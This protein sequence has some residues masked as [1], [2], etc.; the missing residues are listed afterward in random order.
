MVI[1]G[2]S[3]GRA[4]SVLGALIAASSFLV[5]CPKKH[6]PPAMTRIWLG[7]RHACSTLK[8]GGLACWGDNHDA[9][10]GPRPIGMQPLPKEVLQETPTTLALGGRST[11]G[12]FAGGAIR[13]WGATFG[14]APRAVD[15]APGVP[16]RGTALAAAGD[17]AC[18]VASDTRAVWCW[19][20][21]AAA[22][23]AK[24]APALAGME[25][26]A[27]GVGP[28]M[29]CAAGVRPHEVRCAPIAQ[30]SVGSSARRLLPTMDIATISVGADHACALLRDGSAR[31]WGENG[32]GQLGDGTTRA[33]EEPALVYGAPE[34][35]EIGAGR[36]HTCARTRRGTVVC[37]G[38][39][40]V[41]QLSNGTTEPSAKPTLVPGLVGIQE[42]SVAGDGACVRL[43]DGGVRCWGG[44]GA[45][46]LGDGTTDDHPVAMPIKW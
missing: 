39:N 29:L 22:P 16:L 14:A 18:A 36:R 32:S 34:L 46:Q 33:S 40:D 7:E 20:P 10:L 42:L 27:I 6:K 43:A 25:V 15:V 21:G 26:D 17:L 8:T 5:G 30:G 37:W 38:R 35:A 11:C 4:A 31:C 28:T 12:T 19:N 24:I 13:C 45:G 9:Q 3:R 1:P 41:Y 44:N 2:G 23:Q